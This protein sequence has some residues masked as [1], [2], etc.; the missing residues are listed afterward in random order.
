MA[1]GPR[2]MVSLAVLM[3]LK[4]LIV[5]L[6]AQQMEECPSSPQAENTSSP[7]TK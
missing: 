1:E 6:A 7:R 2:L 5:R 4:C 3:A